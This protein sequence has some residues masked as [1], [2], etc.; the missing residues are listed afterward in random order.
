M[1]DE[2]PE[3]EPWL[4]SLARGDAGALAALFNFYRPRLRQMVR[5]RLDKRLAPRLDPSDVLQ[6][7][8]LDAARQAADYLRRPKVSF[9]I[10]LRGLA[11]ERLLKLQRR[12]LSAQRRSVNRELVL[13]AKSSALLAAQLMMQSAKA[14]DALL[15]KELQQRVQQALTRLPADDREVILLRHFEGLSNNE[16]AQTLALSP[17]A[18]TM[19]Y[20]RALLRLKEILAAEAPPGGSQS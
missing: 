16:V 1:P 15:Q 11:W 18:A 20:G 3:I 8:Y 14:R 13:P 12:H 10:W 17:S 2:P 6:E 19:R 7:I 4:Q 9:Y 5:L